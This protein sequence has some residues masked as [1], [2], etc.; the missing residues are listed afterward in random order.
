MI[1]GSPPTR[2]AMTGVPQASASMA[3]SPNG[4]GHDP[5]ISDA[6]DSAKRMIALGLL[7]LAEELDRRAGRL[8]RRHEDVVEVVPL[9]RR[10]A[11]L[12]RDPQRAA[13]RLRDLDRIDDALLGRHPADEA[14]RVAAPALERRIVEGQA[15]V[16]DAGPLDLG[17]GRGLVGADRDEPRRR[18]RE[19]RRRPGAGRAGR[20]TSRRRGSARPGRAGSW[21]TRGGCG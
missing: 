11:G 12:R 15:V 7:E 6:Y 19:A 3:T 16:D 4:S 18:A 17:M 1:S 10:R 21:P 20:G 14:E 2:R 8:E 9:G 13:G 5:G